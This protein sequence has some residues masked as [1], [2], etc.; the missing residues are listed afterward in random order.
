[1]LTARIAAWWIADFKA[2]LWRRATRGHFGFPVGA[3]IILWEGD[4]LVAA[5]RLMT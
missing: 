1:M 2:A 3:R 4:P 5:V